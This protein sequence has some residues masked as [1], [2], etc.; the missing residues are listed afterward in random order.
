MEDSKDTETDHSFNRLGTLICQDISINNDT[1]EKDYKPNMTIHGA[2]EEEQNMICNP[3]IK[4]ENLESTDQLDALIEKYRIEKSY[5]VLKRVEET[6]DSDN[7]KT[8]RERHKK[9]SNST[10][11]PKTKKRRAT[12]TDDSTIRKRQK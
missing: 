5:V 9:N 8:R 11:P 10:G 1:S 6:L 4:L 3:E 12:S 7:M 2:E